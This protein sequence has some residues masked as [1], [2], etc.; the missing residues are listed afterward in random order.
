MTIQY[1]DDSIDR[2]FVELEALEIELEAAD[3][4]SN[5]KIEDK[6][7]IYA[8]IDALDAKIN[9]TERKLGTFAT[10]R[11]GNGY[12][13]VSTVFAGRDMEARVARKTRIDISARFCSPPALQFQSGA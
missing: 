3:L 10:H 2:M 5:L 4:N 7:N 6:M 9:D 11:P 13:Y 8:E 12:P 1:Y